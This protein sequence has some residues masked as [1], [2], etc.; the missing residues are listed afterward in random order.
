[1]YAPITGLRLRVGAAELT[2]LTELAELTAKEIVEDGA[3]VMEACVEVEEEEIGLDVK[4][5]LGVTVV[6]ETGATVDDVPS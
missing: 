3:T 2:A 6:D 1:M 4:E 5:E